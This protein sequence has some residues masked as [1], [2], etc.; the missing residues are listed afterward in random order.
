[1]SSLWGGLSTPR[2]LSAHRDARRSRR[3]GVLRKAPFSALEPMLSRSAC[4][5]PPSPSFP[6]AAASLQAGSPWGARAASPDLL[7]QPL[8][9]WGP[10]ASEA[11]RQQDNSANNEN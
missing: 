2:R 6:R 8:K 3:R 11:S 1:M 5:F 10:D 9:Q 7:V 4:P